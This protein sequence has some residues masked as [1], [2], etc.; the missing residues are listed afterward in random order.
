MGTYGFPVHAVPW[1]LYHMERHGFVE[2]YRG[3]SKDS[4]LAISAAKG[5]IS[6]LRL[7][8]LRNSV[9]GGQQRPFI[10]LLSL[11]RFCQATDPKDKIFAILGVV[12]DIDLSQPGM[13]ISY[14]PS[15]SV[16]QLYTRIAGA[17]MVSNARN[18]IELL[19]E[20][21]SALHPRLPDL[22]SW[23]PDWSVTRAGTPL[24]GLY[25]AGYSCGEF[26]DVEFNLDSSSTVLKLK[27]IIF[28]TIWKTSTPHKPHVET[29]RTDVYFALNTYHWIN[30]ARAVCNALTDENYVHT[31]QVTEEAFWRTLIGDKTHTDLPATEAY[32]NQWKS[33]M[34]QQRFIDEALQ[35]VQLDENGDMP[36]LAINDPTGEYT[37]ALKGSRLYHHALHNMV[38]TRS[39]CLSQDRYMAMVPGDSKPGDAICIVAGSMIPFI[40]RKMADGMWK[41]LGDCYVHGITRG[42]LVSNKESLRWEVISLA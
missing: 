24:G 11:L 41:L 22:P 19:W 42:E 30:S 27:A 39:F 25:S 2:E 1:L 29:P 9:Q 26:V 16:A 28:D 8:N 33:V 13:E 12:T 23:V 17:A 15:E 38:Y 37:A 36:G 18:V 10:S 20:G 32:S 14:S 7:Q 4:S 6:F 40:I 5:K 31:G 3:I 21:G 34:T 35:G